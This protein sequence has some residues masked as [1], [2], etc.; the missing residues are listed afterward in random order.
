MDA[1]Q[2]NVH[3]AALR[4]MERTGARVGLP[5]TGGDCCGALHVHAGLEDGA[6]RLAARVMRSMPGDAAIVVDSAGCG[7]AL[8]DYGHLLGTS[9]AAAFSARVRDIG[10]WLEPRLDLLPNITSRFPVS[11]AIQ[12]PCHLRHV[13]RAHLAWRPVLAR[14]CDTVELDDEGRCCG[15]G[16]SYSLTQPLL[17]GEIRRQKVDAIRRTD[18]TVVASANPG[19]SL[20]LS[21]AGLDVRHPIEIVDE[22]FVGR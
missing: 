9:E 22:V 7:A 5:G 20:W 4:V 18:A 3:A 10:E 17:A 15:A 12:D 6:R 14:V 1:W 2:R 13:Q 19:C 16:G 11:V 8:K 21:A